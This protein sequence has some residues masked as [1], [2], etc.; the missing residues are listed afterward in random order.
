M[1]EV[2]AYT[3][4]ETRELFLEYIRDLVDYWDKEKVSRR[5]A[6][7]GIAFSILTTLD[8]ATMALPG[9]KVSPICPDEDIKYAK[10]NGNNYYDESI[11]IA[12]CLHEHFYKK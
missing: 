9:F 4:E 2:R 8:G 11:D 7:D 5:E 1:K 12:G 6:I 10:E 3:E